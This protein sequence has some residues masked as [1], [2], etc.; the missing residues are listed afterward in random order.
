MKNGNEKLEF[1]WGKFGAI[2][3]L[4]T[5]FIGIM[6]LVMAG[7]KAAKTFWAAG[8]FSLMLAYLLAKDKKKFNDTVIKGLSNNLMAVMVIAF[9]LAGI[10][11][12]L[13]RDGGLVDGFLWLAAQLNVGSQFIPLISFLTCVLISTCTGTT[14]GTVAAVTPIMLPVAVKLGC[15]PALIMGAIISGSFFGDNLAPVSDTTIASAYTQETDVPIVV[16]SRLKYSLIAGALAAILYV[17]FGFAMASGAPTEIVISD[18]AQR[19]LLLLLSPALLV[20]LMIRGASLVSAL[21]ACNI[22]TMALALIGGFITFDQLIG[23]G[24]VIISGIEGM[25]FLT[26]FCV[27]IFSLIEMLNAGGVFDWIIEK[28]TKNIKSARQA[29]TMSAILVMIITLMTAAATVSIVMTGP[30]VRKIFK[31]YSIGR[32]RGANI[33]DGLA[34]GI[35]G[36]CFWNLSCMSA[37]ALAMSTGAIDESFTIMQSM[38]YSFH[39]I[40]LTIVY[41]IA[42]FTGYGR[43]F[44]DTKESEYKL[45]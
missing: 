25:V 31:R 44:E 42:I 26:V 33:L 13:L 27:F 9:Y 14:G 5:T 4:T 20:F 36:I 16:K 28:S 19:S 2:L 10:T 38:P 30:V 22:F 40:L 23:P 41:I 45:S 43:T 8:L 34:C 29:E 15:N 39:C 35:G 17:I 24:G 3:P 18:S 6:L 37:Y 21:L 1:Y 12:Q 32:E 7:Y 11:A